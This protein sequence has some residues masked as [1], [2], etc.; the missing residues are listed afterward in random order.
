[1]IKCVQS[2]LFS[3]GYLVGEQAEH[4]FAALF[5]LFNAE[6]EEFAN[7]FFVPAPLQ[8]LAGKEI[9]D[10]HRKHIAHDGDD[11]GEPQGQAEQHTV[12]DGAST[13]RYKG[14]VTLPMERTVE[15]VGPYNNFCNYFIKL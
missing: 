8:H 5:T 1:M 12:G 15:D 2:Y 10:G 3:R 4:S 13:S 14:K 11:E 6:G 9:N 7:V